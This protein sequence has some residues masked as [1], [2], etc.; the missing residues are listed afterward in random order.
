MQHDGD[1]KMKVE[2]TEAL[3]GMDVDD[4]QEL[5]PAAELVA[6]AS[7]LQQAPQTQITEY[8]VIPPMTRDFWTMMRNVMRE[9]SYEIRSELI[10]GTGHRLNALDVKITQ[11]L[12]SEARCWE[13][14][15]AQ[16]DE[17]DNNNVQDLAERL[18][19][20]KVRETTATQEL[21]T[22][23]TT[24]TSRW[25]SSSAPVAA[26]EAQASRTTKSGKG[27]RDREG[28]GESADG[29]ELT[30]DAP[31][32]SVWT[33]IERPR[34]V[35]AARR[36]LMLARPVGGHGRREGE[37]KDRPWDGQ[38]PFGALS[39]AEWRPVQVPKR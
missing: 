3:E 29:P 2:K 13:S 27:R 17:T 8:V 16:G 23:K 12:Q 10:Q 11:E 25:S 15:A 20:L 1:G 24:S 21:G 28:G 35:Q 31:L 39:A 19:K 4:D 6:V 32:A 22:S 9:G 26:T 37:H 36:G 14:F 30:S 34:S 33:A 18:D 5:I 38:D 7:E